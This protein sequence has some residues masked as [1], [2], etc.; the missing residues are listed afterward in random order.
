MIA[1][2][3]YLMFRWLGDRPEWTTHERLRW[4]FHELQRLADVWSLI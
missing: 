4:R 2:R 3:M 1:A